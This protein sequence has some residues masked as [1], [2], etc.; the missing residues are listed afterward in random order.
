VCMCVCVIVCVS[1]CVCLCVCVCVLIAYM[2]T[3]PYFLFQ[4]RAKQ[5]SG[6]APF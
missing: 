4:R 1:V 5:T 2:V 6:A 3:S